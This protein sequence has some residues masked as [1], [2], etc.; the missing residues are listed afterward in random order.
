MPRFLKNQPLPAKT[1]VLPGIPRAALQAVPCR[2]LAGTPVVGQTVLLTWSPA[3]R[4]ETD[5][6]AALDGGQCCCLRG[7]P[8]PHVHIDRQ[9][10]VS[11]ESPMCV[12][13]LSL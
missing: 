2:V 9:S 11:S 10:R 3:R 13:A 5:E 1:Q 7:R 8:R 12:L 6:A 4:S